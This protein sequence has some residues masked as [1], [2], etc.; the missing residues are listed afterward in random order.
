MLEIVLWQEIRS[1]TYPVTEAY[2]YMHSSP[3]Y[4]KTSYRFIQ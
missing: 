4:L 1:Y 3:I 2:I